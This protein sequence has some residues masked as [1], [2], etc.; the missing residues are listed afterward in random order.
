MNL[1]DKI[2]QEESLHELAY[3]YNIGFMEMAK[4]YQEA[5]PKEIKLM[6][7]FAKSNNWEGFKKLIKKVIDVE[8]KG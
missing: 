1:I 6:E 4:F 2:V 3:R 8:L 5:S 7:K